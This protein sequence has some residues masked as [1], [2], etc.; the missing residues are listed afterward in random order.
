MRGRRNGPPLKHPRL[1]YKQIEVCFFNNREWNEI[2]NSTCCSFRK[3][4]EKDDLQFSHEVVGSH[5]SA[6]ISFSCLSH[7]GCVTLENPLNLSGPVSSPKNRGS[8]LH[9]RLGLWI[10]KHHVSLLLSNAQKAPSKRWAFLTW[11]NWSH[12]RKM[13]SAPGYSS[14]ER[15][16]DNLYHMCF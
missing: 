12:F 6:G 4:W 3:H 10:K 9:H 14:V 5:D 8:Y 11:P 2:Q 16:S 15:E 13:V 1:T 7:T